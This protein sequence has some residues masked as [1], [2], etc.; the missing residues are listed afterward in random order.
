MA[1]DRKRA[2]KNRIPYMMVEKIFLGDYNTYLK[3]TGEGTW[4]LVSPKATFSINSQGNINISGN[5]SL[6]GQ[7]YA[8]DIHQDTV[9]KIE[10]KR[11]V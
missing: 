6:D 2:R 7:L 11:K 8:K 1:Y 10:S 9:D 3:N 5:L 4:E